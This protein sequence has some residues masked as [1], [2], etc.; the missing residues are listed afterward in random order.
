[1]EWIAIGIIR[2][3]IGLRGFCA[4]EPFGASF[5]A[6]EPPCNVRIGKNSEEAECAEIEEIVRR[7]RGYHCRF[8]GRIDRTA[9]EGL[10]GALLFIEVETLPKLRNNEFYH[11]ELK[12]MAVHADGTGACLGTVADVHNFPSMDTLEVVLE[13]G[14]ET[15]MLPLMDQAIVHQQF[16]EE[17]LH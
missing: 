5:G 4:I 2:R 11:F 13:Q 17:L 7:P 1:M 14:G 10:R 8:T 9:V 12:G 16:V 3:P 15:L 6:L